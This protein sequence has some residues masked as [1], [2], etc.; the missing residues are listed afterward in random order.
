MLFYCMCQ[1]RKVVL[2][3]IRVIFF[4]IVSLF[5]PLNG[6]ICIMVLRYP[7]IFLHLQ[8]F[9]GPQRPDPRDVSTGGP[10]GVGAAGEAIVGLHRPRPGPNGPASNLGGNS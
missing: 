6:L 4:G 3:F 7:L 1:F 10:I 9:F 5:A 8:P 2:K